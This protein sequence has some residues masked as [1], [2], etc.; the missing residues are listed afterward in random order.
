ML[1][2]ELGAIPESMMATPIFE[3]FGIDEV[4]T[5]GSPSVSRNVLGNAGATDVSAAGSSPFLLG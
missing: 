1:K 4:A 5:F 3:P 2:F